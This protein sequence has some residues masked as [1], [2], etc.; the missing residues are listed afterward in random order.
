K[1]E[2]KGSEAEIVP[3][4]SKAPSINF[5]KKNLKSILQ[6]LISNSVKFRS[7]YRKPKVMVDTEKT[8][9][10]YIVLRVRDNGLGIKEKDHDKLFSMYCRLNADIPGTGV[11]M[12]IVKRLVENAGGK[13]ELESKIGEGS[14]F[15]VF[16]PFHQ[17]F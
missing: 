12:A 6:N 3:D 15:K 1:E 4:F 9:D 10:G 8:E 13:I 2:I 16:L 17:S 11:G 14:T 5:S 7:P